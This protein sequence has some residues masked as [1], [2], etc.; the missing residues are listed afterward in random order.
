MSRLEWTYAPTPISVLIKHME[1]ALDALKKS[2]PHKM[3]DGS[4]KVRLWDGDKYERRCGRI[5]KRKP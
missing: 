4:L 2:D 3:A 1:E 5:V